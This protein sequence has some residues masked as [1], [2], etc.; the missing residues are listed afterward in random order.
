MKP[1][2][3][4]IGTYPPPCGCGEASTTVQPRTLLLGACLLA[5]LVAV[6]IYWVKR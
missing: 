1:N 3:V 4:G 5:G 6:G 2:L